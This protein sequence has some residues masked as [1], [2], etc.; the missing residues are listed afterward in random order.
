[1]TSPRSRATSS[2]STSTVYATVAMITANRAGSRRRARRIQKRG[3]SIE[4]LRC[5]SSMSSVVIRKPL[6]TKNTSTPRNPPG[7]HE[8]SPW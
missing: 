1:M 8:T 3:R 4:P 6:M 7:I 5:H 2:G